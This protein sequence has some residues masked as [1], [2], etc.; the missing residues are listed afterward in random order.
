MYL[1]I[2]MNPRLSVG[3]SYASNL[4]VYEEKR[5][6]IWGCVLRSTLPE[7][8]VGK[9]RL[10]TI[11]GHIGHGALSSQLTLRSGPLGTGNAS[12]DASWALSTVCHWNPARD[13]PD[14]KSRNSH[15]PFKIAAM[16]AAVIPKAWD[17]I[18]SLGYTWYLIVSSLFWKFP[19]QTWTRCDFLLITRNFS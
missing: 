9:G 8:T 11:F 7:W 12:F 2:V 4:D 15:S 10:L 17:F 5:S 1:P 18:Q 6:C 19:S 14:E 3:G 16:F 13:D